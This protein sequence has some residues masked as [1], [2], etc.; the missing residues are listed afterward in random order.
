M[1][2]DTKQFSVDP[3]EWNNLQSIVIG[4]QGPLETTRETLA[5]AT[6]VCKKCRKEWRAT[7]HGPGRMLVTAQGI[8][9]VCPRCQTEALIK[10]HDLRD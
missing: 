3:L 5:V 10:H 8:A 1:A 9:I 6:I 2:I 4:D 7:L